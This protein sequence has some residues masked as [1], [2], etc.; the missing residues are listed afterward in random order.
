[1]MEDSI[2]E[3]VDVRL[4]FVRILM[5]TG[6]HEDAQSRLTELST[7]VPNDPR[8]L[9]LKGMLADRDGR[10]REAQE[11]YRAALSTR[12]GDL[13]TANNLALSL[14]LSG[15]LEEAIQLQ[16]QV[17]RD[18]SAT[19]QMRQNLALL[20]AFAGRMDVAEQITRALLPKEAADQVVADLSRMVGRAD[21]MPRPNVEGAVPLSR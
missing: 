17:A 9:S 5:A 15:D 19:V 6:A 13:R 10:H 18:P 20:Y 12:P 1:M 3:S 8:V 2:P 21:A 11:A 4:E 16:N 14:A 7:V